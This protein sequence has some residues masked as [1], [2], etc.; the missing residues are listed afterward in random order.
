MHLACPALINGGTEVNG[1]SA[2]LAATYMSQ[3]GS[4]CSH[5]QIR[6]V[7]IAGIAFLRWPGCAIPWTFFTAARAQLVLG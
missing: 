3:F 6:L 2:V 1:A 5:F 4:K 7:S